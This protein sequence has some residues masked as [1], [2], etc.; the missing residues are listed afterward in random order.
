ML[1]A[2]DLYDLRLAVIVEALKQDQ[3]HVLVG[4][5]SSDG[6]FVIPEGKPEKRGTNLLPMASSQVHRLTGLTVTPIELSSSLITTQQPETD[7][8]IAVL[9]CICRKY[10]CVEDN[11]EPARG[12]LGRPPVKWSWVPTSHLRD[13]FQAHPWNHLHQRIIELYLRGSSHSS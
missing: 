10:Y 7:S 1:G 4:R 13:H 2:C 5:Q 12:D 11:P 9:A 6:I 3:F 8:S